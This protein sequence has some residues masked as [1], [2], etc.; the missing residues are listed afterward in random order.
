MHIVFSVD[1]LTESFWPVPAPAPSPGSSSTPSPTQNVADGMT[2]SQSEWAFHRLINELSGSDS[3]PT[4]NTIERSPPPVQSLSRLEETVDETEDVVEIQKPQNHRRL[5][6]D[7]QGKN[8]NRAPSS[9]PVD[10]SA[11]V[12]V[13]PN[14]YHAILKSKLELA[15]AAVARRVGTVKPED[16]SASASNQKQ[17]QGSIVAQTSPG[18]SSVRFSP[19]TSTQKKPDVPARQTSISSRDD[20]DDDDLDGDA[21]NG[22][23]TDVK[24][25]R[26]MLS[27]RESARRSRRRKQEQMNEFDTQVRSFI[28]CSYI[29]TFL[30][31]FL[32]FNSLQGF[33]GK[34]FTNCR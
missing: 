8:R 33:I 32:L 22:D 10:S 25:A 31:S 12:V 23:P 7:D 20:S 11:P 16:S 6:V 27:N 34:V 15:C 5:P 9:D 3:S 19:T 1:D 4:T 13:D 14:Q 18:A 21:D 24:R 26:R 2:R 17:A 29:Y 30:E 28:S